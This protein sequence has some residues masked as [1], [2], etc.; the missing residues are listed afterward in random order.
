MARPF[1]GGDC[2]RIETHSQL[3]QKLVTPSEFPFEAPQAPINLVLQAGKDL[4]R[5]SP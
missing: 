5:R 3:V 2:A 1:Y 4:E